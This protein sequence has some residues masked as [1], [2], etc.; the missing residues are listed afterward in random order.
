MNLRFV[1]GWFSRYWLAIWF[2]VIFT[3]RLQA[4]IGRGP[5]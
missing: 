3:I 5:G 1:T 2:G 4:F